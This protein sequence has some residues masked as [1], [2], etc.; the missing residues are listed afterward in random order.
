MS[1]SAFNTFRA[2]ER[3]MGT[4]TPAFTG[5]GFLNY[6]FRNTPIGANANTSSL[7]KSTPLGGV[8]SPN[9]IAK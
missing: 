6:T 5:E 2:G 7:F 3:D 4:T 8:T 1:E 9:M